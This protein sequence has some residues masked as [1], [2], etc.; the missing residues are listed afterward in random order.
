MKGILCQNGCE[1]YEKQY[2][3]SW[4]ALTE[5]LRGHSWFQVMGMVEWGQ[6]WKPKKIPSAS[7]N[8]PPPPPLKQQQQNMDQNLTPQNFHTEFLSL[9]NWFYETD[10]M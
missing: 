4:T 9:I 8:N 5:D 1:P 3:N 10:A 2:H 6:K 7:N